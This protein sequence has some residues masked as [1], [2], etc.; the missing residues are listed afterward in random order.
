MDLQLNNLMIFAELFEEIVE[1]KYSNWKCRCQWSYN[2]RYDCSKLGCGC[3]HHFCHKKKE[4]ITENKIKMIL[5]LFA[6][7]IPSGRKFYCIDSKK[8]LNSYCRRM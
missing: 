3:I 1:R 4:Q 6:T 5:M 7:L 2:I 8:D